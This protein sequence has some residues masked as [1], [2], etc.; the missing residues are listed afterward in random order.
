MRVGVYVG[1]FNPVHKAHIKVAEYLIEE[2]LLDKVLIIPTLNYWDKQNLIDI[3]DRINM[4]KF[5]ESDKIVIDTTHNELEYTYQILNELNKET[6]DEYY[7]IIGADNLVNF[8]L[9]KNVNDILKNKILVINR[10]GIDT[11]K[12]INGRDNFIVVN[13][14]KEMK[15]S[16][17]EIREF[18]SN[19]NYDKLNM[20]LDKEV[21]AYIMEHDLYGGN[22]GKLND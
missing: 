20:Y 15:I 10:N 14:L 16:S 8:H 4:L 11:Q 1:S 5:Y 3:N 19:K 17:T 2:N 21:I 12:Y 7:L 18:I 13:G 22:N 6:S 9:W